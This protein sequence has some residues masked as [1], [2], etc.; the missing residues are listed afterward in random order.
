MARNRVIGANG[1]IPW[2]LPAEL[3]RFRELTLGHALVMGR[4]T[5]ESIGRLL[6]GRTS[7]IVTRQ[8]DYRVPGAVIAHSIEEALAACA[9]EDEAFVIGGAELYAQALPLARRLYLTVVEAE[10][11]GDTVM[12]E[13]D[14]AS[15]REVRR[16]FH[17]ADAQHPYAFRCM[18]YERIAA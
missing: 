18:V 5:F 3:R 16:S 9:G 10:V 11:P 4:K 6:P 15:W 2:R 13:F 14:L 17:P 8:R 7:V 12:P 1:T